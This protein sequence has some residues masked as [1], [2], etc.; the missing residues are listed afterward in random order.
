MIVRV[1]EALIQHKL[2]RPLESTS[3][4]LVTGKTE[5]GEFAVGDI[6]PTAVI[7]NG[8]LCDDPTYN[9]TF[10][11][12]KYTDLVHGERVMVYTVGGDIIKYVGDGYYDKGR[13]IIIMRVKNDTV[14][15]RNSHL[16]SKIHFK[17]AEIERT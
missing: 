2:E 8:L 14:A 6:V 15:F 13:D 16:V 7:L 3:L 9:N 17:Y 11:N 5:L 4:N 10:I 1:E 12:K